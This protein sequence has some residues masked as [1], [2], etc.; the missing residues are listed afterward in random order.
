MDYQT[1]NKE[2]NVD[3]DDGRN[4]DLRCDNGGNAVLNYADVFVETDNCWE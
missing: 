1:D 2:D 3:D 4:E